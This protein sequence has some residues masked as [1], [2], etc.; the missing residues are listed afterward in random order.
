LRLRALLVLACLPV[1]V[2]VFLIWHATREDSYV[3]DG[4]SYWETHSDGR[5]PLVVAVLI[6]LGALGTTFVVR[7]R[8]RA[9]AWITVTVT[10]VGLFAGAFALLAISAN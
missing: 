4:S 5:V 10:I 2:T 7:D 9:A 3:D 6:N 8:G 1:A